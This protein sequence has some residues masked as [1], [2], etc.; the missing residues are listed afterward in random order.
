M[1]YYYS[2]MSLGWFLEVWQVL[3][4]PWSQV[5]CT[6]ILFDSRD[7]LSLCGCVLCLTVVRRKEVWTV[8]MLA[9]LGVYLGGGYGYM[10]S[11]LTCW[12]LISPSLLAANSAHCSKYTSQNAPTVIFLYWMVCSLDDTAHT[13]SHDLLLDL[14]G[15]NGKM[16]LILSI[17]KLSVKL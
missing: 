15:W 2:K 4:L 17:C 7:T 12:L 8:D 14:I 16:W 6:I 13:I 5:N 9:C 10:W 3:Q 11:S 1:D